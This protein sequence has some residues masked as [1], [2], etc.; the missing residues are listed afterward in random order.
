[1]KRLLTALL[2]VLGLTVLFTV[3]VAAEDSTATFYNGDNVYVT[4]TA[5]SDGTVT[6]P[7]C[8]VAKGFVGWAY[9]TAD[10]H[11]LLPAGTTLSITGDTAFRA[12]CADLRTLTGAAVS[13]GSP[14][15]LRFDGA[16]SVKDYQRLTE[17]VGADNVS[18]GL[19]IS[20]TTSVY[21]AAS[22]STKFQKDC[23]A[24][25]L[26]DRSASIA[27]TTAACAVFSGRTDPIPD[28]MLLES[29]S[30]RA[31]LTVTTTEGEITIYADYVPEKHDRMAHFV[32]AMAFEDRTEK[33][34][35][36][37]VYTTPAVTDHYALYPTGALNELEKR[38]DKVISVSGGWDTDPIV[39]NEYAQ[40]MFGNFTEF[41]FY[42]S[43]YRVDRVLTDQPA[44]FDTYVIVAK[45]G[46]DFN[47]IKVYFVGHSYRPP[48]AEEWKADGL[49][50][51]V[52]NITLLP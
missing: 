17:L 36:D 28:D 5:T 23:G 33:P 25:G 11:R 51:S 49:Y 52:R 19:L 4:V 24:A 13:V 31:Y 26:L 45:E 10:G 1:M 46:A 29:Y 8:T 50:I 2:F 35:D 12:V 18:V 16:L 3:T 48:K 34:K 47:H 43:P 37:H 20:P 41:L 38:L 44:G 40:S 6:L 22:D 39:A 14:T 27:Y 21:A 15:T 30:A 9:E 42:T 7:G 32:T